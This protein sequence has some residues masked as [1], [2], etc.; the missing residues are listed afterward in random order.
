M[1]AWGWEVLSKVACVPISSNT[2][3]RLAHDPSSKQ[4]NH[5]LPSCQIEVSLHL[6]NT[7]RGCGRRARTTLSVCEH[8]S[9]RTGDNISE[10]CMPWWSTS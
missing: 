2:L 4:I 10:F 8:W 9:V 1:S 7:N 5:R 3:S 6:I